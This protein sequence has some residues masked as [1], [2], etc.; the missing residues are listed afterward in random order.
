MAK[1]PFFEHFWP[2]IE[3]KQ[4]LDGVSPIHLVSIKLQA[5]LRD[6]GYS[7]DAPGTEFRG[8]DRALRGVKS[9]KYLRS[10]VT[11]VTSTRPDR[12]TEDVARATSLHPSP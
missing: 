12:T 2:L 9:D 7:A 1:S 5:E 4:R 11:P 6:H 3:G 10:D 8:Y